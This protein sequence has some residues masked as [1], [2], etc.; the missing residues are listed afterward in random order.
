MAL[1]KEL[2]LINLEDK[3]LV[4]VPDSKPAFPSNNK[5]CLVFKI[6][7][8]VKFC[9]IKNPSLEHV[10]SASPHLLPALFNTSLKMEQEM[11]SQKEVIQKHQNEISLLKSQ[12]YQMGYFQYDYSNSKKRS[13]PECADSIHQHSIAAS[14]SSSNSAKHSE[15]L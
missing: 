11:I 13:Y 8:W 4:L 5:D 12:V 10:Q 3:T 2:S 6:T 15:F 14:T 7:D 1:E 9:K